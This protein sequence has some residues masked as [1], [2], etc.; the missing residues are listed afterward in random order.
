MNPFSEETLAFIFGEVLRISW[1]GTLI[2]LIVLVLRFP[3]KH[4]PKRFA[5]ILW[6]AVWLRLFIPVAIP[7]HFSLL[8]ATS[9]FMDSVRGSG[10]AL[11][12]YIGSSGATWPLNVPFDRQE[13][14]NTLLQFSSLQPQDTINSADPIQVF[15]ALGAAIW[16]LGAV[17]LMVYSVS[18]SMTTARQLA[19]ATRI[20]G[21]VFESERVDSP[22]IFG[23]FKPRI[24]VPLGVSPDA[25]RNIVAHE[26]VHLKSR[27]HLIKPFIYLVSVIHWF[28]PLVWLAF[29]LTSK[30]MEMACDEQ[31][32]RHFSKE[33]RSAYSQT[34]LGFSTP[35]HA[36][37]HSPLSFG[38][39]SIKTRIINIL[40]YKRQP[41]WMY[42]VCGILVTGLVFSLITTPQRA[43]GDNGNT[44]PSF[45]LEGYAI[46]D[47]Q[48]N[49][50][51]YVGDNSKVIALTD[52][53][54]YPEGTRRGMVSLHT[55]QEPYGM[56]VDLIMR[57]ETLKHFDDKGQLLRNA[58]LMMA[59][60]DN[61]D[62]LEYRLTTEDLR[63]TTY[64]G[65]SYDVYPVNRKSIEKMIGQRLSSF[66]KDETGIL[67]ILR[68]VDE[69]RSSYQASEP[70]IPDYIY[71]GNDV[72]TQVVHS[73]VT[74][75]L[76][77]EYTNQQGEGA[78]FIVVAPTIHKTVEEN[79]I[80]KVF[81]TVYGSRFMVSGRTVKE[82]G[83]QVTPLAI[84]YELNGGNFQVKT[85]ETSGNGSEFAPSIEAFCKTPVSKT[86]VTGLY[87]TIMAD[88]D[89]GGQAKRQKL[90]DSLLREHLGIYRKGISFD[91]TGQ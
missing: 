51:P 1:L 23:V 55:A 15:Y 53:V 18:T 29:H 6:S 61:L 56:T 11:P 27:D 34:L 16:F 57:E 41:L 31:V 91:Y 33:G 26:N 58:A 50:T 60:I 45:A 49:Y 2:I 36:F 47:L 21:N 43:S 69:N 63:N 67:N 20:N 79:G 83:G 76:A 85:V 28:N 17:L 88:Y 74:A 44:I 59:F 46:M 40:Q 89:N 4:L 3:M 90:M 80:N 9:R 78:I 71:S 14:D 75:N 35:R 68:L 30:D 82:I 54:P 52:C 8:G 77:A 25:L 10:N 39:S 72:S 70:L 12:Q 42:A 64:S 24:Y 81:A 66:N 73:V 48:A 65:L 62:Y 7:S 22:F 5:Y 38:E 13:L 37:L 84:T 19:T 32:I 87:D 86:P